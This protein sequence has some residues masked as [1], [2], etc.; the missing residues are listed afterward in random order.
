MVNLVKNAAEAFEMVSINNK[1]IKIKTEEEDEF[2][3]IK[4]SN[5]AGKIEEPS[6]IF[7]EGFTTKEKG[8]G[9]GLNICK[10]SI[11]SM[12]G[13][14]SLEHTGEDYTEFAIR[15]AKVG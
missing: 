9:L 7:E 8:S 11:E 4:V 13:K 6:R 1:Y 14:L 5:N 10:K 12:Y 15:I 3:I 2:V